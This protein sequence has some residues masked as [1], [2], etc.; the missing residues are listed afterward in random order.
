ML[1]IAEGEH[2]GVTGYSLPQGTYD[3]SDSK[4]CR[5]GVQFKRIQIF[6]RDKSPEGIK[7]WKAA[8]QEANPS[9]VNQSSFSL[10]QLTNFF[11]DMYKGMPILLRFQHWRIAHDT[12]AVS[13]LA[14]SPC[15]A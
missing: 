12:I 14:Y 11:T 13:A 7:A 6:P 8:L 2:E 4:P 3:L 15:A 1:Q 10:H 9:M 5:Q